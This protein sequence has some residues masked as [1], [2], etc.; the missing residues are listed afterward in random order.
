LATEFKQRAALLV[1]I[2]IKELTN[3]ADKNGKKEIKKLS[4]GQRTHERRLK[5]AAR[6]ESIVVEIKK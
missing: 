3:M 4:K 5:Q 1:Q 2:Q 6:K